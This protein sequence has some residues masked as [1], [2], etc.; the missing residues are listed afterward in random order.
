MRELEARSRL[1]DWRASPLGSHASRLCCFGGNDRRECDSVHVVMLGHVPGI[2]VADRGEHGVV[3][4]VETIEML[5]MCA[6]HLP[7]N[8]G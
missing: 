6:L 5:G 1:P 4:C 2:L 8:D 3:P 7:E